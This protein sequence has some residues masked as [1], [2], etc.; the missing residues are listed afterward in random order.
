MTTADQ[1]SVLY[2]CWP[3]ILSMVMELVGT[4]DSRPEGA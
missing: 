4:C 1:F 3:S 2:V